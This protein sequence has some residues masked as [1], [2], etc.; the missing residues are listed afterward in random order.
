MLT[1]EEINRKLLHLLALLM[2][3]GIFYIPELTR[4]SKWT[5][6]FILAGL[7]LVSALAEKLRLTHP[8]IQKVYITCFG[9]LMR[10]DE[11]KK[12]TGA[13][14]IIGGAWLC[15]MVFVDSPHISFITLILFILGDAA[16]A[17]V[18]LSMGRTRFLGKSMEGS[19]ACFG[20]CM[21]LFAVLFPNVP[22]L[23]NH[24]DGGAV[25]FPIMIATSLA[26]T[27]LELIPIKITKKY[28]LN[29]NLYVPVFAGVVMK[30]LQEIL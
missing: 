27:I 2:P 7:F 28:T 11:I 3:V 5:A 18:G 22:L 10:R 6:P 17:L 9:A 24:W 8:V 21:T 12:T 15:S 20:L 14:Y 23:M 19:L 4:F 16:A 1:K 25:P 30:L 29:D 26:V 13:T